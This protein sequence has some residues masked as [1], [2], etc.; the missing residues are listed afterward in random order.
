MTKIELDAL[1]SEKRHLMIQWKSALNGLSRRDE[2]RDK[3]SGLDCS[4]DGGGDYD[5]ELESTA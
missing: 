2:A 1:A 4:P 5:A 3:A